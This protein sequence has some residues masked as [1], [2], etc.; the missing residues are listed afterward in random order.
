VWNVEDGDDDDDLKVELCF[1]LSFGNRTLQVHV[2]R[3]V[4]I[5]NLYLYGCPPPIMH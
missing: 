1:E 2:I 3:E 5:L 4:E